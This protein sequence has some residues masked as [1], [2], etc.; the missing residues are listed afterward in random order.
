MY[1]A[2]YGLSKNPC[3]L[4]SEQQLGQS[5]AAAYHT[6]PLNLFDGSDWDDSVIPA[7]S[8]T[9]SIDFDRAKYQ[10]TFGNEFPALELADRRVGNRLFKIR[11]ATSKGHRSSA[12]ILIKRRYEWRGYEG[13]SLPVD[14]NA[15]RITLI[16]TEHD[17]IIGTMTVG[18]DSREGLLADDV[19]PAEVASFRTQGRTVCEF[20]KLAVGST[21]N[22]R[23]TS[24]SPSLGCSAL[25]V[26]PHFQERL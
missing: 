23:R 10:L 15:N 1:E 20:T 25:I 16:A 14:G 5:V 2:A 21:E 6:G 19:F 7:V 9:D 24:S 12:N 18:L 26:Q 22:A 17:E 13:A 11:A 4:N 8:T 3:Q